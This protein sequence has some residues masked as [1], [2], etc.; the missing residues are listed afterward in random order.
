ME[1]PSTTYP[2]DD[3]LCQLLES[4]YEEVVQDL[5]ANIGAP[6]KPESLWSKMD[7][8]LSER[9]AL[10]K[11]QLKLTQASTDSSLAPKN[12]PAQVSAQWVCL[13]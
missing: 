10:L 6:G 2:S 3:L 1:P 13:D 12:P 5:K 7:F 8:P 9:A 4:G 11:K